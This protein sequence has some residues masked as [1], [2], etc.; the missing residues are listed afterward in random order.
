M[1]MSQETDDRSNGYDAIADDLIAERDRSDVGASTVRT[2]ARS[3]PV[4]GSILDL[5][6]GHGV[7]IS[8]ALMDDGFIVYGVDASPNLMAAFRGRFPQANVACEA[9][10][11][12]TFFGRTFDG[13]IAVGLMFLLPAEAQRKLIHRVA[14]A[15]KPRARFLFTAPTQCVMWA[16]ML[17]GRQSL[18]LGDET[19]KAILLEAGL[20]LVDQ[21]VDEGRNHYYDSA[22]EQSRGE[23]TAV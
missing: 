20:F 21:Y 4:G 23:L 1:A 16:D 3:L 2:W 8:A 11:D 17:T 9:A 5:G 6:C 14:L 18:S 13:I 7:P 22:K 10:E 12:S 15:L 19:Y